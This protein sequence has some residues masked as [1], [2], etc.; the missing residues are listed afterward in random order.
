[1]RAGLGLV[2]KVVSNC[3]PA[4]VPRVHALPEVISFLKVKLQAGFL[5]R[6]GLS[7]SDEDV[8]EVAAAL[9]QDLL[10]FPRLSCHVFDLLLYQGA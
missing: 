4:L 6:G 10:A 2:V 9:L 3:A 8:V 7:R 1:M 5:C